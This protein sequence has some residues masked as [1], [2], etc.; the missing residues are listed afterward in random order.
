MS[1]DH[2]PPQTYILHAVGIALVLT[3]AMVA[4]LVTAW[5]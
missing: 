2:K 4:F 3:A 5:S 1:A